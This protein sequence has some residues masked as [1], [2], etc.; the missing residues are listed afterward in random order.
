MLE[1]NGK[2]SKLQNETLWR[3]VRTREFIEWFGNWLGATYNLLDKTLKGKHK[4]EGITASMLKD[5]PALLKRPIAV[6]KGGVDAPAGSVVVITRRANSNDEFL[7]VALHPNQNVSRIYVNKVATVHVKNL[8]RGFKG[9]HRKDKF[10]Y[11]NKKM[12]LELATSYGSK[13]APLVQSIQDSDSNIL[14]EGDFVNI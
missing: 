7:S 1:P 11:I 4:D 10:K 12:S 9:W 8:E 14:T 2:V 6:L 13:F 5:I 3:T